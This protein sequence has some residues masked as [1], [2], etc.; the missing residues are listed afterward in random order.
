MSSHTLYNGS[1]GVWTKVDAGEGLRQLANL[2]E[3]SRW[4]KEAVE[5][6]ALAGLGMGRLA[7]YP[8]FRD[9]V[10]VFRVVPQTVTLATG[11]A[12]A[13]AFGNQALTE[14][15]PTHANYSNSGADPKLPPAP[16][17]G[18]RPAFL[19]TKAETHN[20]TTAQLTAGID[21]VVNGTTY[22]VTII[23]TNGALT[24]LELLE[25]INASSAQV[26]VMVDAAGTA[27]RIFSP[28]VG[29]ISSIRV[30]SSAAADVLFPGTAATSAV[31]TTYLGTNGPIG[32][33]G[34]GARRILPGSL[35]VKWGAVTLED[36]MSGVL[37]TTPSS[38]DVGTIDYATGAISVTAAATTPA[39]AAAI[40]AAYKILTPLTLDAP[41]RF[42]RVGTELALVLK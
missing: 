5:P 20:I 1:N 35:T 27:V 37:G 3:V 34:R 41:V 24:A 7:N 42:P 8:D 2:N 18:V 15:D 19:R 13:T 22:H 16:R 36:D 21:L 38:A 12:S 6:Q 40:T 32:E 39:S 9:L 26:S 11:D 25:S 31:N 23:G 4:L 28:L 33:V 17:G 29:V 10:D 30:V 14:P